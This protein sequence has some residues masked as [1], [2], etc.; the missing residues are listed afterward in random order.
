M[1]QTVR[2][3][4]VFPRSGQQVMVELPSHI[5]RSLNSDKP[6]HGSQAT[7]RPSHSLVNPPTSA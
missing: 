2:V 4:L 7:D 6:K 3:G 1:T 5:A